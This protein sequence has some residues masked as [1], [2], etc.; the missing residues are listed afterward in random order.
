[1]EECES[2]VD[3]V[4]EWAGQAI[5]TIPWYNNPQRIAPPP[6]A[7]STV[8]AVRFVGGLGSE[9]GFEPSCK[10]IRIDFDPIPSSYRPLL[11]YGPF[12]SWYSACSFSFHVLDYPCSHFACWCACLGATAGLVSLATE[13]FM[14]SQQFEKLK[15]GS[16]SC[17]CALLFVTSVSAVAAPISID[18]D[19]LTF[20]SSLY[21][22][23][24]TYWH[25]SPCIRFSHQ[26]L[27][28]HVV[29]F[30]LQTIIRLFN[31][32]SIPPLFGSPGCSEA[33]PSIVFCHGLGVGVVSYARVVKT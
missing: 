5:F 30:V 17:E 31:P 1:M 23:S 16:C 8:S 33:E 15:C 28:T 4:V 7:S 18:L 24:L 14:Y 9:D 3:I 10:C 19:F 21:D 12:T 11:Y 22:R 2:L 32:N 26:R 27:H 29:Q 13:V 20:I 25:R 6:F